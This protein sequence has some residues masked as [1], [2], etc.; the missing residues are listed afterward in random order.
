MKIICIAI[1]V[2]AFN[3]SVICQAD[4]SKQT[5]GSSPNTTYEVD[6]IRNVN[7]SGGSIRVVGHIVI[8]LGRTEQEVHATLK[9]AAIEIGTREHAKATQIRG[10]RPQDKERTGVF[11]VGQ[12]HYAPNGRWEDADTNAPMIVKVELSKD[13]IYFQKTEPA[14]TGKGFLLKDPKGR[15]IDISRYRDRWGDNDIIAKLPSGTPVF[16][17]ERHETTIAPAMLLIRVRVRDEKKN[18][19][20]WVFGEDVVPK[21]VTK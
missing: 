18:L 2:L 8:P 3:F 20:G 16:V 4:N 6:H 21:K 15:P 19:E 1:G 11:T 13:S 17:I 10:Y 5:G 12:A 9:K 7:T 14:K